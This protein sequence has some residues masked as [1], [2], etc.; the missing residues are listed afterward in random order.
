LFKSFTVEYLPRVSTEESCGKRGENRY[1]A[2]IDPAGD[3]HP[4]S[5]NGAGTGELINIIN[6]QKGEAR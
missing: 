1:V 3:S 6:E 4:N 5:Y 2:Y